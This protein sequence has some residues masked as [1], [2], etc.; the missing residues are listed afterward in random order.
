MQ[1][2]FATVDVFTDRQFGGNPLAVV[3][4]R[5]S[6]TSAQMQVA[7]TKRQK[8]PDITLGVNYAWGGFGG[9]S[10]NGP[11]GPQSLTFGVSAPLPVR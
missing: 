4:D 1:L 3:P 10:T 9:L 5:R 2:N 11:M 7:L 8:F 6:L